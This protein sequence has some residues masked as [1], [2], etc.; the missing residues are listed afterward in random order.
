MRV[1][2][3]TWRSYDHF[4]SSVDAEPASSVSSDIVQ[5]PQPAFDRRTIVFASLALVVL[6][7]AGAL[8]GGLASRSPIKTADIDAKPDLFTAAH[9]QL[10]IAVAARNRVPAVYPYRYMA[11]DGGLISYGVD[12][13][14]VNGK[15]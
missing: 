8:W 5:P 7:A 13:A 10:I 11:A 15:I 9:H 3:R 4:R 1:L 6:L 14:E 12:T 2:I